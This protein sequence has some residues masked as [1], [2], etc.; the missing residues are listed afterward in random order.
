MR[1]R[2]LPR[3]I[4]LTGLGVGQLVVVGGLALAALSERATPG[5]LMAG[6]LCVGAGV[7]A[8]LWVLPDVLCYLRSHSDQEQEPPKGDEW[9][10]SNSCT[11]TVSY[12]DDSRNAVR[13]TATAQ[14]IQLDVARRMIQRD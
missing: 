12:R 1:P 8:V 3:W 13:S 14:I 6:V 5:R 11:P 9:I 7:F 10:D 4:A 2:V